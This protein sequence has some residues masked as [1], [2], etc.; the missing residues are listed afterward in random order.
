M[1][2]VQTDS[3]GK[4]ITLNGQA[5]VS[6]DL[7]N[8][9]KTITENGTYTA[10]SGYNG[11]GTVTVNVPSSSSSKY[12]I[13]IDSM[14]GDPDANGKL[15]APVVSSPDFVLPSNIIDLG[16]NCLYG[17][18]ANSS[19]IKTAVFQGVK[20]ITG[21]NALYTCF[22]QSTIQTVSFPELENITGS[23]ALYQMFYFCSSVSSVTFP[24][25]KTIGN[26][27][28]SS[29]MSNGQHFAY[30][31]STGSLTELSFPELTSIYCTGSSSFYGT[32][33]NCTSIKKFYFPKLTQITYGSGGSSTNQ[34]ACNYIF[35]NC[36]ALTEIHFGSANQAAIEATTGYSTIWGRG[37]G[38]ATI[39]F[40]L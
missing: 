26:P 23:S 8:Q 39:Y 15:L 34:S 14:F 24:K 21:N 18:F 13:S 12:G 17:R 16:N 9:N 38:N 10:D 30:W 29:Y 36:S 4:V 1:I 32:F 5:L 28:V 40:D 6:L 31:Y 33:Y 7:P 22:S 19:S 37:A 3:Q 25:L 35:S 11:L 2:K 20:N 27:V